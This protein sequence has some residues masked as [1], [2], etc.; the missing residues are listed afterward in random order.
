MTSSST[1]GTGRRYRLRP[2]L[3]AALSGELAEKTEP[4]TIVEAVGLVRLAVGI[5][6][7]V[8]QVPLALTEPVGLDMAE[9]DDG[10]VVR[11]QWATGEFVA[12]RRDDL[13]KNGVENWLATDEC[14]YAWHEFCAM[15]GVSITV[16]VPRDEHEPVTLPVKLGNTGGVERSA[17]SGC[18]AYM[19]MRG[20]SA[21]L[22]SG[23]A[24]LAGRALITAADEWDAEQAEPSHAGFSINGRRTQADNGE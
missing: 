4:A 15:P 23:A 21:H 12:E 2:D 6:N 9:P 5:E 7:V 22:A 1:V 18:A 16:L 20:A 3:V 10:A 13:T 17:L 11:V 24:R 19:T 8:V 14:S